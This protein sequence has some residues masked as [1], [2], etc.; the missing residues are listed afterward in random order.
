M[1][2]NYCALLSQAFTL[3]EKHP[4]Y[5]TDVYVPYAQW[6][7]EKDRFEEAQQGKSTTPQIYLLGLLWKS[8]GSTLIENYINVKFLVEMFFF[9]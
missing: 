8:L 3:V 7:A 2:W 1:F 5:K 4:E 9:F 6:L